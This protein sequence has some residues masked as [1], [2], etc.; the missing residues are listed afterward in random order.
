MQFI[1]QITIAS[2]SE[3]DILNSLNIIGHIQTFRMTYS[4]THS[5]TYSVTHSLMYS[6]THPLTYSLTHPL[7]YSLTHSPTHLPIHSFTHANIHPITHSLTH[8]LTHSPTHPL[9]CP[10]THSL[11]HVNIYLITDS[12]HFLSSHHSPTQF[13]ACLS[14]IINLFI[15]QPT[16]LCQTA[17]FLWSSRQL[18]QLWILLLIFVF[19]SNLGIQTSGQTWFCTCT[20][21]LRCLLNDKKSSYSFLLEKSRQTTLHLKRI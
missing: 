2:A 8:S 18:Y 14:K 1:S 3:R 16:Y 19:L 13:T 15:Y 5:L 12:S 6:L 7:T 20:R 11:T 10:S 9:T 4:L 21:A 17:L